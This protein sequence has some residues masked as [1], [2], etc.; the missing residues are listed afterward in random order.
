MVV[1]PTHE[2]TNPRQTPS[3]ANAIRGKSH[4]RQ[5]PS[6]ANAICGKRHLRQ[7]PSAANAI[8][9]NMPAD[10]LSARLQPADW[11]SRLLGKSKRSDRGSSHSFL[12][13]VVIQVVLFF[14]FAKAQANS[15]DVT[16]ASP[17][18]CFLGDSLPSASNQV[19]SVVARTF[20]R[21]TIFT[22]ENATRD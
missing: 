8:C 22:V 6:A 12:D 1:G 10:L 5:T 16:P 17:H 15:N 21:A 4:P 3:A 7:A 14:S 2:F 18:Q 20:D 19:T 11:S 13:P 9:G